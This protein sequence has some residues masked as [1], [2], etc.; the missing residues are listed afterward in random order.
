MLNRLLIQLSN[1]IKV[2]IS[3]FISVNVNVLTVLTVCNLIYLVILNFLINLVQYVLI[4]HPM[5]FL[6][7]LCIIFLIS[8]IIWKKLSFFN[9]I[10]LLFAI[11]TPI[12]SLILIELYFTSPILAV[13][14]TLSSPL[15]TP[16][17]F[18]WARMS[19]E[20]RDEYYRK[21]TQAL[22]EDWFRRHRSERQRAE[23]EEAWNAYRPSWPEDAENVHAA[24]K[25]PNK[26]NQ[27][28]TLGEQKIDNLPHIIGSFFANSHNVSVERLMDTIPYL[29]IPNDDSIR[30]LREYYYSIHMFQAEH[31]TAQRTPEEIASFNTLKYLFNAHYASINTTLRDCN[32]EFAYWQDEMLKV[33]YSQK[34]VTI[35]F[36]RTLLYNNEKLIDLPR[37]NFTDEEQIAK[38]DFFIK[39]LKEEKTKL[40]GVQLSHNE[41]KSLILSIERNADE[42]ISFVEEQNPALKGKRVLDPNAYHTYILTHIEMSV[43]EVYESIPRIEITPE[44]K[45]YIKQ[46]NNLNVFALEEN[47]PESDYAKQ[48]QRDLTNKI[49]DELGRKPEICAYLDKHSTDD[50]DTR[51]GRV[52]ELIH[53]LQER[54]YGSA[55][56][57]PNLMFD[58]YHIINTQEINDEGLRNVMER[59]HSLSSLRRFL[60]PESKLDEE[61]ARQQKYLHKCIEEHL[62]KDTRFSDA[63]RDRVAKGEARQALINDAIKAIYEIHYRSS[64]K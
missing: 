17:S 56:V 43:N 20:E 47:T 37:I 34:D 22:A 33:G 41:R 38:A 1:M 25:T 58:L 16:D 53:M 5:L 4:N 59:L 54:I 7:L 60:E 57:R 19:T 28:L 49:L 40:E 63:V 23:V 21:Q 35:S 50:E 30:Q 31:P 24:W 26:L 14:P 46:F 42:L 10:L 18:Q 39:V 11:T 13:M 29:Y 48:A 8:C 64:R 51:V 27:Y 3:N 32:P 36:L 55:A 61:Y 52:I 45:S 2:M 44:L 12:F 62:L 15:D 9:V 6:S